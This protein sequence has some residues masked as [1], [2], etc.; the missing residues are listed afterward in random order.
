MPIEATFRFKWHSSR[1][2]Y[3]GDYVYFQ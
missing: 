3:W 2:H 1:Q